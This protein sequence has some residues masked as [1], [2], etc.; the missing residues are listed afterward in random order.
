[1]ADISLLFDVAGGTSIDKGSGKLIKE[2]LA[3]IIDN[4]NASPLQIKVQAD[5]TSL[6]AFGARIQKITDSIGS[7]KA[8]NLDSAELVSGMRSVAQIAAAIGDVTATWQNMDTILGSIYKDLAVLQSLLTDITRALPRTGSALERMAT[9]DSSGLDDLIRKLE[10]LRE[11]I[12]QINDK[13]FSVTNVFEYKKGSGGGT[14]ELELYRTRA[15]ET[16]RVVNM[17]SEEMSRISRASA[18]S[19]AFTKALMNSGE[20]NNFWSLSE[21]FKGTEFYTGE[22]AGAS[23]IASLNKIIGL[24]GEYMRVYGSILT[25]VQNSGINI[26]LPDTSGLDRAIQQI[27]AYDARAKAVEKTFTDAVR[28]AAGL[29]TS[30]STGAERT[31]QDTTSQANRMRE[32]CA[33]ISGMFDALRSKILETFDFATVPMDISSIKSVI[34]QIKTEF[35]GIEIR[36]GAGSTGD[37]GNT[38]KKGSSGGR[39]KNTD[40]AKAEENVAWKSY[41]AWQEA[42]EKKQAEIEKSWQE[43]QAILQKEEAAIEDAARK[44]IEAYEKVED[45]R[46][47]TAERAVTVGQ[48]A[49]GT[50]AE[51]NTLYKQIAASIARIRKAQQDW[52]AAET[53]ETSGEYANLDGYIQRLQNLQ[54]EFDNLNKADIKQKLSSINK[55]FANSSNVIKEAGE[56]T[57][58]WS[59]RYGNLTRKFSEWFSVTR[60]V[61]FLYQQM[62]RMV[63]SVVEL[64]TAMTEL[65]KVTDETDATY[66]RFLTNA[67]SRTRDLGASLT[68]VVASTADFARLGYSL[69]EAEQMADAAIIYKNVGDGI[70]DINQ[71]SE[72]IIATMQAF[73]IEANDVMT[74][75]DRFNAIGNK[76][77]ITSGGVGDAL[78]RSAAAMHSAGNTIDET[79][80]LIAAANTIVQNPDT[81]GTTLKTV[82]M[83]LRTA[84]TEAEE[85]GESTEGMANS[86]SELRQEILDLTGQRVDIQ[87]DENTFKGTYQILKELSSV[88]N[89]LSDTSQANILEMIGGKRNANIVS[90]LLKNF[91]VAEEALAVSAESAGSALAENEKVLE[92][93]QGKLN[94][95]TATFESLSS[96][97]LDSELVK[98]V[99]EIITGI[100]SFS[101]GIV[102]VIDY[103]G[104]LRTLLL[105]IA[106][107]LAISQGGL[108]AY[109]TQLLAISAGNHILKFFRGLKEGLIN[110]ISAIPNAITA[111]KAYKAEIVSFGT[112]I[113]ASI[114]VIGL[115]LT[116]ITLVTAGISAYTRSQE[117]ARQKAIEAAESAATLSEEISDLVNTYARLSEAVKTDDSVKESLIKTEDELKKKLDLEGEGL[118]RLIDKYGTLDEAI[119]RSATSE[120]REQL[121]DIYGGINAAEE[122]LVNAAKP[123]GLAKKGLNHIITTWSSDDIAENQKALRALVEEG[124]ITDGMYGSQGAEFWFS[125]MDLSS[126]EGVIAA[127]NKLGQMI[128]VVIESAG[129]ENAVFD[130]LYD[131]YNK[132]SNEAQSLD[133]LYEDANKVLT[134]VQVINA[135]VGRD[136]PNTAKEYNTFRQSIIDSTVAAGGFIGEISDIEDTVDSILHT[137]YP[138]FSKFFN[139]ISEGI[140]DSSNS[141]VKI[142]SNYYS[143]VSM[144]KDALNEYEEAGTVSAETYNALLNYGY[145]LENLFKFTSDGIELQTDS[146]ESSIDK[147]NEETGVKLINAN[148]TEANIAAVLRFS[149]SLKQEDDAV[150][151]TLGSIKELV[152]ME[153]ELQEGV[154]YSSLQMLEILE[155]YPELSSHIEETAKG[156][157]IETDAI[158]DLVKAKSELYRQNRKELTLSA[159]TALVSTRRYAKAADVTDEIFNE[160]FADTG[161]QITTLEQYA[162]AYAKHFPDNGGISDV[163]EEVIDYAKALME[164]NSAY[165]ILDDIASGNIR[166]GYTPDDGNGS[167]GG[168]EETAFEREYKRRQHLLNMDKLSVAD[169]LAWLKDAYRASYAAGEM[170]LDDYYGYKEEVYEKEKELFADSISDTEHQIELLNNASA[171]NTEAV[172]SLYRQL[173]ERVHAQA[174]YYRSEGL[175]DNHSLIQEL[176]DQWWSYEEELA[177]IRSDTFDDYLTE[178]KRGI[179]SMR[180]DGADATKVL[181]SWKELLSEINKEV[182]YYSSIGGAEARETMY[183]LLDEAEDIKQEMLDYIEEFVTE[184][185]DTL[186]GLQSAYTAFTDAA[187]E[188]ASTGALAPDTIQTILELSP[189]YLEFL[190]DENGQLVLNKQALQE[191]IAV[192]TEELAVNNALA[193]A[194]QV[195]RA[196]EENDISLLVSLTDV[197]ASASNATWDMAY[198]TLGLAKAIG[199]ANGMEV[200]YFDDAADYIAKIQSLAKTSATAMSSYFDTLEDGYV[201]QSDALEQILQLT[202]NLIKWENEQQIEA[203]EE[204]KSDYADIIDQKKEML[205]V[206]KE[207]VSRERSLSDK[208]EE[209]AKLQAQISQLS[210]DDSR[211]AQAEKRTLEAELAEL[212][213]ELADEQYDYSVE[214]SED[215]LDRE[216]EDFEKVKDDEIESLENMLGSAERLYQ[217]A[218]ERIDSDW[219]GLYADLLS[220]NESYG[221]TLQTDLISAWDAAS[222]AVRRYGSYVEA[223]D[224]V[225]NNSSLGEFSGEISGSYGSS[226]T[227]DYSSASSLLSSM[228]KNSLAWFTADSTERSA[229]EARQRDLAS[230]W[231][232]LYGE[233]LT[234]ING[235]WY[236]PNG[237]I[238]YSLSDDEVGT[239]IVKE[240]EK[241]ADAWHTAIGVREQNALAERNAEL[242]ELLERYL[243]QK[244]TKSADGVWWLG[245]RKLFDVYHNGGIVGASPTLKQNEVMAVLEDGEAVLDAQKENTLYR[246]VD[247]VSVLSEKLGK[248]LDSGKIDQIFGGASYSDVT[249]SVG[250]AVRKK[251]EEAIGSI[252]NST[253][254]YTIEHID[255]TA[256]VQV[257]QKLDDDEIRRYA[258][259]IG[260]VSAEY[261]K[262]GFTKRGI[263]RGASLI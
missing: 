28:A 110:S 57:L 234:S 123:E 117:E 210:L 140:A 113:Q 258:S 259:K 115:L 172:V 85:A 192:K 134:E 48:K 138:E 75:V 103:L 248:A 165:G 188:Y 170:E 112:A 21:K 54:G 171:D 47:K 40:S 246:I 129:R 211:E 68:D 45:A 107:I 79:V 114:P 59:E 239:A 249:A 65:R 136:L 252:R 127:H 70:E 199:T 100:L 3:A 219:E 95:L 121:R 29:D 74:I 78:L 25:Q 262:E 221:S 166:E 161:E 190:Y 27:E 11:L 51:R 61:S 202:Q 174:E 216:L 17:L 157:K 236:R 224:G 98:T 230:E 182:E 261:I 84:K 119:K 148:A 250:E 200:S 256:P 2:Q 12:V 180:L 189:K 26:M 142:T 14:E 55:E 13:N 193:Y 7:V 167:S 240:M 94:I 181:D 10:E 122:E 69:E 97:V 92:S 146:L 81:V 237:D 18:S 124:F 30:E 91:T 243:G 220:W 235:S 130:A 53:G 118:D 67:V 43:H 244:I 109:K 168:D 19:T 88:F 132:V 33:E 214:V 56:A 203:L 238:L 217:A 42:E 24:L 213:K 101:D 159:R 260:A 177:R 209:I 32:L 133:D 62:L 194:R 80:A 154:E 9:A 253:S 178:S 207:Q 137:S 77:A 225:K 226:D 139:T 153:A 90:A 8:I 131:T 87:I 31:L 86:V 152:D 99:I 242:A 71:A 39:K 104:G 201:S 4:I 255:V 128:D 176:Q 145:E 111:W 179:E 233:R 186:D 83:Y 156:Y 22:I 35:D 191:M 5:E 46:E 34:E 198:A 173:Q 251:A 204:Q 105:S 93:I 206:T 102:T 108:I 215:A 263:R 63:D 125:D 212:Q 227:S 231:E 60:V 162:E 50:A 20:F 232:D 160:Y 163:A 23:T 222:E 147:L 183:S 41:L 155:Q 223:L 218:I 116:T 187:R 150:E 184:A 175:D 120:L 247:F 73:G 82:S 38:K 151:A 106:S 64:D 169:Y 6:Q 37:S 76:F 164:M 36:V 1:M 16:L 241:N 49:Y 196:A 149:D 158:Q 44:E 254:S 257:V 195:L 89:T 15:L 229:I 126:V 245:N 58:T 144:L 72:S 197:S 205:A 143:T 52:N 141:L 66:D 208:L 185:N 96:N 135:T 228:K